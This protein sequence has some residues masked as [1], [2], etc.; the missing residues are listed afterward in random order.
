MIFISSSFILWQRILIS[1]DGLK[2]LADLTT[3][4]KLHDAIWKVVRRV[5]VM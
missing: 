2:F 1:F 3:K 4:I 5:M